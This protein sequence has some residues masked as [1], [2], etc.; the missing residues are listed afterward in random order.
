MARITEYDYNLCVEICDL[1]ADGKSVIKALDSNKQYPTWSTF[2]RWK[3]DNEELQT[4]YARSIQDKSEMVMF[5]I[6]ETMQ[7]MRQGKITAGEARVIIDTLKWMASKFYPK[8]FGDKV[9][10][11]SGGEKI[12]NRVDLLFPT[13]DELMSDE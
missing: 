8:M 3:Q 13:H 7:E 10:V 9:D 6:Q 12:Q 1:V 11:T 4:L 2:R 5:E